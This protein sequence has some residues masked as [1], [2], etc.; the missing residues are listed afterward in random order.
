M[1]AYRKT[2]TAQGFVYWVS[3]N[4]PD[5]DGNVWAAQTP[6]PGEPP[7]DKNDLTDIAINRSYQLIF[8]ADAYTTGTIQLTRDLGGSAT[9]PNVVGLRGVD[10]ANDPPKPNE[11][12]FYD[13]YSWIT[14]SI[15]TAL[16]LN[17]NTI[18]TSDSLGVVSGVPIPGS[19]AKYAVLMQKADGSVAFEKLSLDM[20]EPAFS[21]NSF[22]PTPGTPTLLV[23]GTTLTN[24]SFT[25]S[26]NS[27]PISATISVNSGAPI[28]ISSPF[29]TFTY[30]GSF[31]GTNSGYT[32]NFT[33]TAGNG[34]G[35]KSATI[36]FTWGYN[37]YSGVASIWSGISDKLSTITTMHSD[38]QLSRKKEA[39]FTVT[40]GSGQYIYYATPAAF[41]E[42]TFTTNLTGGFSKVESSFDINGVPYYVY[43]SEQKNLGTTTV[44]VT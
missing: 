32:V 1:R 31:T 7:R 36:P 12:L 11:S 40:A 14:E 43:Q 23:V 41:G 17:P 4:S 9:S 2:P 30:T 13:G 16:S 25:M 37:V 15:S 35:T 34:V 6:L 28:T 27:A 42:A 39:G 21:I 26:Y 24:P 44:K 8:P 29:N 20:L 19:S 10:L 3:E 38:I 18:V 33:L 22:S 5:N